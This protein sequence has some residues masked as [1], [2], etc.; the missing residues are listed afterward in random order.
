ME[1]Y[2]LCNLTH[3]KDKLLAL[4]GLA[5]SFNETLSDEYVA[6]MWKKS[7]IIDLAWHGDTDTDQ[8]HKANRAP[9]WSWASVNGS[10]VFPHDQMFGLRDTHVADIKFGDLVDSVACDATPEDRRAV[11]LTGRCYDLTCQWDEQKILSFSL[12]KQ[13]SHPV[14]EGM[15]CT[16]I[17][18]AMPPK[19]LQ[20]YKNLKYL[21]LF[22]TRSSIYGLILTR[23]QGLGEAYRRLG[24]VE[25]ALV[26]PFDEINGKK[27]INELPGDW[28][29]CRYPE[30]WIKAMKNSKS[31][32]CN[33]TAVD[34]SLEISA[35]RDESSEI[36]IH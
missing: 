12:N 23:I 29:E 16:Q 7:L 9:S 2:S 27:I 28:F 33:R 14:F 5:E 3:S 34:L 36:T 6:G 31:F 17:H 32:L 15:P 30:R 19:E 18:V 13:S 8:I 20:A 21:P 35:S 11:L 4:K 10:I 1:E 24:C 26:I 22:S 25:I